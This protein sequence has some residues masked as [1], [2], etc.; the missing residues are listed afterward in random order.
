MELR[1]PFGLRNNQ[2]VLI[3]DIPKS[4]NGLRCN[5]VCPACNEPFEARMGDVRRHHFA[6]SGQGCD[7]VNAYL[8]GLYMLLCEYLTSG[9]PL[10]LPPVIVAFT[11][12]AHSYYTMVNVSDYIKLLSTSRDKEHEI[13]LYGNTK[14]CFDAAQIVNDSNGKPKA[15]LAESHGKQ[16]AVRITPPDTVCKYGAVSKYQDLPTVEIDLADAADMIQASQKEAVFSY[17]KTERSIYRWIYN[18]KIAE[19]FPEIIKRSKAYY[20]AEQERMKREREAAAKREEAARKHAEQIRQEKEQQ[21]QA[22]ELRR[23]QAVENLRKQK[24]DNE[25]A[26]IS[27]IHQKTG[28]YVG[29]KISGKYEVFS[30][31]DLTATRPTTIQ[32]E[33]TQADFD[34]RIEEIKDFKVGGVRRLYAKMCHINKA[35]IALLLQVYNK[36]SSTD[37]ETARVIEYLMIRAGIA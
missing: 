20:D 16:L 5:C 15:I 1:N 19:A 9:F 29:S 33:Y 34:N 30:L 13:M 24:A 36:L 32:N 31:E 14:V 3:E 26:E 4:L 35:E 18:P 17:L 27:Q 6:H 28:G 21:R 7:E 11:L 23:Q 10:L 12:S 8:T 22:N 25:R 37:A 2:I